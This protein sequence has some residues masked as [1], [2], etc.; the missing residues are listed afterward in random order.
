MKAHLTE[1]SVKGLPP[2]P[3]NII[4]YDEEVVGIAGTVCE[5]QKFICGLAQTGVHAMPQC[6]GTHGTPASSA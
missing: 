3:K 4:A 5:L 6:T 1:R 2:Q